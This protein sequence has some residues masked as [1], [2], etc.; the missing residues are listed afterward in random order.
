MVIGETE[1]GKT[2]TNIIVIQNYL[3][4]SARN[5]QYRKALIFDTNLEPQYA[6][7]FP[8]TI[9]VANVKAWSQMP[10]IECRRVV[11]FN[12]DGSEMSPDEQR[13]TCEILGSSFRKGLLVLDDYDNYNRGSAKTRDSSKMFTSNRHRSQDLMISHQALGPIS[14]IEWQNT[15]MVRLHKCSDSIDIIKD[16]VTAYEVLKIA[17]LIVWEQYHLATEAI[18]YGK[19]KDGSPEARQRKGYYL[20]VNVRTQRISGSYSRECFIRNCHKYLRLNPPMVR[21]LGGLVDAAPGKNQVNEI[22]Q[23]HFMRYYGGRN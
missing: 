12:P 4:A 20:F 6:V 8:R 21:Q 19:I 13:K 18:K 1:V 17:E 22:I 11:P 16:R 23:K 7:K 9:S 2:Y 5:G 15:T 14:T 10:K 3:L